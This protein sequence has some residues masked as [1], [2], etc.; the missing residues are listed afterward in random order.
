MGEQ[1]QQVD[2]V[3][4]SPGATVR[5]ESGEVVVLTEDTF[6]VELQS[7]TGGRTVLLGSP[8]SLRRLL[9]KC[10]SAVAEAEQ[11]WVPS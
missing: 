11:R 1:V 2:V 4:V 9:V 10:G 6:G 5:L 8:E 7:S 3:V